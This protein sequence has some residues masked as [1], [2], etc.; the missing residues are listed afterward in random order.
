MK[1]TYR[2]MLAAAA[3]Q[4]AFAGGALAQDYSGAYVGTYTA[5]AAPGPHRITLNITVGPGS[6]ISTTYTTSTGV[7]G[8]CKGTLIGVNA[9]TY[10]R[11]TSS[12]YGNYWGPFIFAPGGVTWTYYGYDCHSHDEHGA[13]KAVKITAHAKKK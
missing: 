11:N 5:S 3:M 9:L 2:L 8:E 13:G 7:A 10:C 12:C 4:V 1:T 6:L